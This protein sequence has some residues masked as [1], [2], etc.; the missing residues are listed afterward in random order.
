M[1]TAPSYGK[2]KVQIQL[3]AGYGGGSS[4]GG[5]NAPIICENPSSHYLQEDA[6]YQFVAAGVDFSAP[7]EFLF[8]QLPPHWSTPS[9]A[10]YAGMWVFA[11]PIGRPAMCRSQNYWDLAHN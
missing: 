2:A 7:F 9:D 11:R 5:S 6:A 1:T 3:W 8:Y 4:Y 10:N